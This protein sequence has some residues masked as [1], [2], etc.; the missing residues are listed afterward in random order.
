MCDGERGSLRRRVSR[1]GCCRFPRR[2]RAGVEMRH[3]L[4]LPYGKSGVKEPLYAPGFWGCAF[5]GLQELLC[6]FRS[7]QVRKAGHL[8]SDIQNSL[9]ELTVAASTVIAE[10]LA[11]VRYRPA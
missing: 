5:P 1:Y 11:R 2:S 7:K 4:K 8:P 3:D 6:L 9:F 10:C